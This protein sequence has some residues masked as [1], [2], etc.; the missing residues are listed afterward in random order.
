[1]AV[2]SRKT[3]WIPEDSVNPIRSVM[4]SR[5]LTRN[6]RSTRPLRLSSGSDPYTRQHRSADSGRRVS[7]GVLVPDWTA[8]VDSAVYWVGEIAGIFFGNCTGK[9]QTCLS[10]CWA[11]ILGLVCFYAGRGR[12]VVA[13]I[14]RRIQAHIHFKADIDSVMLNWPEV[15]RRFDDG[16]SQ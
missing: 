16:L 7:G 6:R 2:D 14:E 4:S 5:R 12:G 15:L 13:G 10:G 11:Q 3:I 8:A 1:M 9:H